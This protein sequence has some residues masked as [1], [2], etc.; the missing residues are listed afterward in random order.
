MTQLLRGLDLQPYYDPAQTFLRSLEEPLMTADRA[1]GTDL[2]VLLRRESLRR[3]F[4]LPVALKDLRRACEGA[5]NILADH[6]GSE[7]LLAVLHDVTRLGSEIS[8]ALKEHPLGDFPATGSPVTH[9]VPDGLVAEFMEAAEDLVGPAEDVITPSALRAAMSTP[10]AASAAALRSAHKQPPPRLRLYAWPN[11]YY[12]HSWFEEHAWLWF[13]SRAEL[14][15]P[16]AHPRMLTWRLW[17]ASATEEWAQEHLRELNVPIANALK[18]ALPPESRRPQVGL[19]ASADFPV[20]RPD[21][22]EG[23]G[24]GEDLDRRDQTDTDPSR[25]RL[26][27]RT[28]MGTR[29]ERAD[30]AYLWDDLAG[31]LLP[32]LRLRAFDG[33]YGAATVVLRSG[34][35]I[36]VRLAKHQSRLAKQTDAWEGAARAALEAGDHAGLPR[37][38]LVAIATGRRFRYLR[39]AL[40]RELYA[41]L[42]RN[43]GAPFISLFPNL[44]SAKAYT[45]ARHGEQS[46]RGKDAVAQLEQVL[47]SE[48]LAP[49]QAAGLIEVVHARSTRLVEVTS[50]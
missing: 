42:R 41:T 14:R 44:Q 43:G 2:S 39:P 13:T 29:T 21:I 18:A 17:R 11:L 25:W 27:L 7:P 34:D 26:V 1:A 5:H 20:A 24:L 16:A 33:D 22:S 10:R 19:L 28:N 35:D 38:D 31:T 49:A 37:A 9:V 6:A 45:R 40:A 30:G 50:A 23:T 4:G 12:Q 15:A 8:A 32:A 36:R 46:L 48:G 47:R 3:M